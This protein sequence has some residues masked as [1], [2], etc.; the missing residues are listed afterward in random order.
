VERIDYTA[1][2]NVILDAGAEIYTFSNKITL[3][4]YHEHD[5]NQLLE[6]LKKNIHKIHG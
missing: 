5:F 6:V 1:I 3:K 4:E 2:Q